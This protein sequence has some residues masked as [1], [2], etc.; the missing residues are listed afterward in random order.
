[1]SLW[2]AIPTAEVEDA[3]MNRHTLQLARKHQDLD[4]QI[5]AEAPRPASDDLALQA[6]TRR[7]LRLKEQLARDGG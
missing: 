4:A 5:H 7:K 3:P 6:L 2:P 1:M